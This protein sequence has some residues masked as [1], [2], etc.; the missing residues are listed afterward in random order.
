MADKRKLHHWLVMLRHIKLWQLL[1]VLVLLAAASAYLL[2]QNNLDM[3]ERRNLV[4]QA[5]EQAGDVQKALTSLQTYVSAHMNTQLGEGVFL[6]H[7]Y[8]RT[9]DE[10]VQKAA[11]AVNPNSQAYK[12]IEAGCRA[13][14]TRTGSFSA[15]MGCIESKVKALSP[16]SDPL[17]GVKPPVIELYKFNFVS[18]LW[19]PDFAGLAVLATLF[20]TLLIMLRLI[21]YISLKAMLRFKHK[22]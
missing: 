18:P 6:E 5:D 22:Q 9:Y 21:G 13:D 4:K 20:V 17:A 19:S 11:S 12:D 10:A 2:R 15:Y 7:T 16:G 8:Q 1:I 3:V 14:Y